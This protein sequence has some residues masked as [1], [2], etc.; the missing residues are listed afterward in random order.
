MPSLTFQNL[1]D[2]YTL[3]QHNK[4][5][6][7]PP[8]VAPLAADVLTLQRQGRLPPPGQLDAPAI[9]PDDFRFAMA[10]ALTGAP[11][12]RAARV[13]QVESGFAP[14][15]I[16]GARA[17]AAGARGLMQFL[18]ETGAAYGLTSRNFHSPTAQ[19]EAYTNFLSTELL[20]RYKND[21]RKALAHYNGGGALPAESL[22]YA[23]RILAPPV[24]RAPQPSTPT[25]TPRSDAPSFF[26]T[27]GRNAVEDVQRTGRGLGRLGRLTL[28]GFTPRNVG[29]VAGAVVDV[30]TPLLYTNPLIPTARAGIEVLARRA[31]ARPDTAETL[32]NIA[33]TGVAVAPLAARGAAAV[34]RRL[35][36]LTPSGRLRSAAIQRT[37]EEVT[38]AADL[39]RQR[40][41]AAA[42][43]TGEEITRAAELQREIIGR[44]GYE[45]GEAGRLGRAQELGPQLIGA[46][47]RQVETLTK[48]GQRAQAGARAAARREVARP[49]ATL[50]DAPAPSF[51][52]I[53]GR[54]LPP[55]AVVEPGQTALPPRRFFSEDAGREIAVRGIPGTPPRTAP[56]PT[57]R[58]TTGALSPA[59][60]AEQRAANAASATAVSHARTTEALRTA[61][62][63]AAVQAVARSPDL[64]T[65]LLRHATPEEAAW[66]AEAVTVGKA[67]PAL[68]PLEVS[69]RLPRGLPQGSSAPLPP[70]ARLPSSGI[71]NKLAWGARLAVMGGGYFTGGGGAAGVARALVGGGLELAAEQMLRRFLDLALNSKAASQ[72]VGEIARLDPQGRAF[73][74]TA[75][76]LGKLA[77][78]GDEAPRRSLDR[79]APETARTLVR[80]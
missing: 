62:P 61:D 34:G 53:T 28:E 23:D 44:A 46:A 70:L 72:L 56:I 58:V 27:A 50:D 19:L 68:G 57:A 51:N 42:A 40:A 75:A 2:I 5:G 25:T 22:A 78:A 77:T 74:A 29:E 20:P 10:D 54:L 13:A 7:L 8:A 3:Q 6:D 33:S 38:S 14:D 30:S 49:L 64:S 71:I 36:P 47:N 39:A 43:T 32:G 4:L 35:R 21:W 67:S 1:R 11:A 55:R 45:I 60:R 12:G 9:T 26:A 73:A 65:A 59:T 18:P 16:R 69:S 37:G 31:G 80:R 24:D 52:P 17:S 63:I 66:I 76:R 79:S 48:A 41:G 15:V